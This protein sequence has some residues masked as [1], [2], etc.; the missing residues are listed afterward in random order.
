MN[1]SILDSIKKLL[2][3]S[4]DDNNFDMDILMH[5]NASIAALAQMGIGPEGG[6]FITDNSS[7]WDDLLS[8]DTR[9]EFAKTYIY[10]KVRLGFDPPTASSAVDAINRQIS[11]LE[12][13][14]NVAVEHNTQNHI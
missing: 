1:N 14:M 2:G 9:L 11:E 8:G 13:R 3:I 12:W 5:I 6:L 7:S 4:A 10:Y